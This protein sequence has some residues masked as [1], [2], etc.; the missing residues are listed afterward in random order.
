MVCACHETFVKESLTLL[1]W[2]VLL[3]LKLPE[4]ISSG[5]F[6]LQQHHLHL[7]IQER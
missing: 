1:R 7:K 5:E 4:V 2:P 3:Y 6:L